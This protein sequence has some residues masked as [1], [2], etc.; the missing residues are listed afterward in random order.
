MLDKI[1]KDDDKFG[2]TDDNFSFKVTIF[3]ISIDKLVCQK[4]PTFKVPLLCYRVKL[5][6]TTMQIATTIP[7]LTE[8]IRICSCS[9]KAPSGNALISP[10]GRPLA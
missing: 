10:N 5:R 4:M 7:R 2:G 8:F 9:L 6:R 3:L 1:Y